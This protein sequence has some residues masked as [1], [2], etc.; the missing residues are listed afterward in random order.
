[1]KF[2]WLLLFFVF[3]IPVNAQVKIGA[4]RDHLPY[5][6]C[7]KVVKVGT[8]V[9]CATD[10]NVF[11]YNTKDNSLQKLSKIT[12]LSDIGVA[13]MEYSAENDELFIAYTNG[14]IDLIKNQ[15]ITNIPD[16]YKQ[17]VPGSKKANHIF[18]RKNFAYVS[19]SFG[20]VVID[21]TKKEIK[22][23]YQV[24]EAGSAYEVL[25]TVADDNYFYAATEKGIFKGGINDPFLVNY[26]RWQRD[27][28][29]PNSSGK[30]NALGLFNGK[31]VANFNG[32]AD[33]TDTLYYLDNAGWR[34]LPVADHLNHFEIREA[35][36][37][38]L[39]TGAYHA[40]VL[41][42]TMQ[43]TQTISDYGF[44][45][46]DPRS[47]W[48]DESSNLWIADGGNGLVLKS[49]GGG[50][51]SIYP[52][53]PNSTNSWKM[54][55]NNGALYVTAGG[56]ESS[57]VNFFRRGELFTFKN[58]AWSN[59]Y[60]GNAFDFN[61]IAVDPDDAQKIYVSS[62]GSG[63]LVYKDGQVSANYTEK[64]SPL[65]NLIL[66]SQYVRI[67]GMAF[68]DK[69]NLW[70][71]NSGAATP[72]LMRKP[73]GTWKSFAWSSFIDCKSINDIV[74]D[75]N[76]CFWVVLPFQTGLFVFSPKG[77]IDNGKDSL[78]KFKPLSA[79]NEILS[80]VYCVTNDRDGNVWV[81]TD[82]GPVVYATPENV[83]TGETAGKQVTIPR[84][85][86]SG[87]SD[88]M[89]GAET[90]NCITVD[91]AN[92][93][94]FGTEKGGAFLFSPDGTRQIYHFNTSN[95]PLFSNNVKTIGINDQTGEVFFGTDKGIISLRAKATLPD[96]DFN[97]VYV[98]PNPVRPEY[99]G[100]IT[101]TGL[102]ENTI[103]KITDISGNLVYQTKSLGGQATWDGKGHNGRKVATGVYLVFCSNEDG[104]KTFVTK[105]LVVH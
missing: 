99:E 16:I 17:S 50:F 22:D 49:N 90:V 32:S 81:G 29:I 94:W 37:Q 75:R 80:N 87:L 41:S 19:Y 25:A 91:G 98:F 54:L 71:T 52:N 74:M 84:S 59:I 70:V 31:I 8:L 103:V 3:L 55:Y 38:L 57:T 12:G 88:V 77:P 46:A 11:T 76:G 58:E 24:G 53:G 44:S 27:N 18:F 78:V 92:C 85:D 28:T 7:K 15:T 35:G 95:S 1:M 4:W 104:S 23:T 97:N 82:K 105:M 21:L 66:G 2:I 56:Y 96:E 62:W 102:I 89:L 63:V 61:T 86:G 9:Y 40:Y 39:V 10:N 20:I 48:M 14:N 30:F 67:G 33:K 26:L 73:D 5:R 79:F 72:V 69:K 6:S 42:A 47:T 68:D 13:N 101:I 51:Q 100:I 93:K 83:F 36:N 64:N 34:Y 60:N 65:T 45:G 43:V